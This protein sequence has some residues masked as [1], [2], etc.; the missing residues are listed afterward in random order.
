[1]ANTASM[2]EPKKATDR[3]RMIFDTTEEHRRAVQ[4]RA[5]AKGKT[6]S[7]VLNELIAASFRV[8][9]AQ[10]KRAMK[11]ENGVGEAD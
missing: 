6:P 5:A 1:M 7:E 8:E 3:P 10:A 11:E 4:I 2:A 9:I